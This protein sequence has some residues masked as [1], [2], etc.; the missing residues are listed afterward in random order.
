MITHTPTLD[1]GFMLTLTLALCIVGRVSLAQHLQQRWLPNR[2]TLLVVAGI[3]EGL[4]MLALPTSQVN[5]LSRSVSLP[6]AS[7][8]AVA[9]IIVGMVWFWME[10]LTRKKTQHT[11]QQLQINQ[12]LPRYEDN[13]TLN[14]ASYQSSFTLVSMAISEELLYRDWLFNA[15]RHFSIPIWGAMLSVAIAFGAAHVGFGLLEGGRKCLFSLCLCSAYCVCSSLL[16]CVF[17]HVVFNALV[18]WTWKKRSEA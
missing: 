10:K 2:S 12:E 13:Q 1:I 9:G 14:L 4:A 17:A 7:S 6:F 8:M 11:R 15:L 3:T 16:I 18:W 5:N